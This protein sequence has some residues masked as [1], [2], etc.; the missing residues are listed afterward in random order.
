[1]SHKVFK[2][3]RGMESK[4]ALAFLQENF[5]IGSWN[6]S[7]NKS[8]AESIEYTKTKKTELKPV[9]IDSWKKKQRRANL[10]AQQKKLSMVERI[11]NKARL[12]HSI[13][14]KHNK[15]KKGKCE[16]CHKIKKLTKEHVIPKSIGGV[17][18]IKV[19]EY[20][21][22]TRGTSFDYQPFIQWA[23]THWDKFVEALNTAEMPDKE[24]AKIV[25]KVM[26]NM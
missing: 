1:M 22:R 12:S 25:N 11:L 6:G 15:Y 26:A 23:N 2:K 16:Y 21:N 7:W 20:C 5:D 10:Q 18:T 17:Y 9:H 19:C 24:K 4:S 13:K 3:L 14:S 8:S